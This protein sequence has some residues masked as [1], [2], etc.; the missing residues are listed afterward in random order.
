M[1]SSIRTSRGSLAEAIRCSPV[2][3]VRVAVGVFVLSLI[4]A[5]T[6]D[7]DLWGHL[8]FGLDT[9][10]S[11]SV[12]GTDPYSFTSDRAWINHE[13]LAE[14]LMAAAYSALGPFGLNLLKLACIAV[15]GAVVVAVAREEGATSW[16]RDVFVALVLFAVYTRMQAVRPQLFSVV[17][18]SLLIYMV[19]QF[20]RGH[21]R[22][23]WSIPLVFAAWVNLHGG[24][25]VGLGTLAVWLVGAALPR[26]TGDGRLRDVVT[27][28]GAFRAGLRARLTLVAIGAASLAATLANPYAAGLWSF[29]GETVRLGR[30]DVTDWKPLL[31]LPHAVIAIE[32]VLPAVALMCLARSGWRVSLRYTA[33]VAVL[34]FATFRIGRTDAFTHMAIALLFAPQIVGGLNALEQRLLGLRSSLRRRSV[35]VGAVAACL[36]ALT[37]ATVARE[38][39]A[40]KIKGPWVP[41]ASGAMFLRDTYPGAR[42]LTWFD[43]GE[44]A[45]WHLSPTGARVSMDGRRET[46]YSDRVLAEHFA[47]YRGESG[48]AD[49]PDRISADVVWLPVDFP[50]VR[51]LVD[52]GWFTVFKSDRSIVLA[53][54]P[55]AVA[56]ASYDL[57][58]DGTFPG[59]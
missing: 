42:V 49:Y 23:A 12:H 36:L 50:S 11:G 57:A 25:L 43:W 14:V 24:W 59:P 19:R 35:L 46:V 27:G 53:R 40:I 56:R 10:S 3:L 32:M 58:T 4:V 8:R 45:V 13:W 39:Q 9:L 29:L 28:D 26:A 15:V 33:I 37:T 17:L 21:P 34:V 38:I 48:S 1:P 52:K 20:D 41:D 22:A 55:L 31:E 54:R 18:F 5:T 16:T 51:P 47:F 7:A 2:T 44:Y 6:A 30:P